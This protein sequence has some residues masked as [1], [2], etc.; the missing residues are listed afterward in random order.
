MTSYEFEKAAKNAVVKVMAEDGISVTLEELQM[1]WFAHVLGHKKCT[2]FAP[3]LQEIYPEVTYNS[4]KDEL[5]VDV[6]D[7]AR[8]RCFKGDELDFTVHRAGEVAAEEP[9]KEAVPDPAANVG[10]EAPI[11]RPKAMISQPMRG[12]SDEEIVATRERA[13]RVLEAL[14]YEVVNTLFTDEWYSPEA[15]KERG[16]VQVPLCFL[17]K[18]LE[19]MSMCHA[20]YF[21]EGWED[22]R[23]CII[24]HETALAYGVDVLYEEQIKNTF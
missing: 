3:G 14:G 20:T 24:E 9:E 5:Y 4:A 2:L 7:K 17:A 11:A 13:I 16:V 23:G 1:V 12:K 22:A 15:M 18:S 19:N 6:Y 8:N 10:G 21:C